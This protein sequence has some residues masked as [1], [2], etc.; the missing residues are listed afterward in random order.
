ML[1]WSAVHPSG[2]QPPPPPGRYVCTAYKARC[3]DATCFPPHFVTPIQAFPCHPCR[4][5]GVVSSSTRRT[6]SRT[7]AVPPPRQCLRCAASTSGHSVARRCRTEWRSSTHSSASY[8]ERE[9]RGFIKPCLEHHA[10][11]SG[12]LLLWLCLWCLRTGRPASA[13]TAGMAATSLPCQT[14]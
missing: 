13:G 11:R 10:I 3:C 9:R 4:C 7:G 1:V 6:A 2:V 8:G 14:F 12:L 5:R